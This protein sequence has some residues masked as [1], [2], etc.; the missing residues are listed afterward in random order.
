MVRVRRKRIPIKPDKRS[1]TYD[2][3]ARRIAPIIKRMLGNPRF[4]FT[5]SLCLRAQDKQGNNF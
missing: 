1:Q 5:R 4:V 3:L 2:K